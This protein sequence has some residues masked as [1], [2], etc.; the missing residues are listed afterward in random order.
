MEK[1][2]DVF[3]S[4]TPSICMVSKKELVLNMRF[5]D[6]KIKPDGNY[7]NRGQITTKNVVAMVDISKEKWVIKREFL[8]KYDETQDNV[9]AGLEDVRLMYHGGKLLFN[10]NRGM[11]H[12]NMVIEH[13]SIEGE[14]VL[15]HFLKYEKQ[16][17]IEKNWVMFSDDK[18]KIKM[19]YNWFPILVGDVTPE[20]NELVITNTI[21]TPPF[22]R[23]IRG[24][25]NG[26]NIGN[27][28]WFL[29]HMVSY[30][31]RRYYYHI[32]VVLDSTT[33]ALKKYTPFF[34]FTKEKVEYSLGFVHQKNDDFLIGYSVLDRTTDFMTV[35]K[36]TIDEMMIVI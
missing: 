10:A 22:F 26:V 33:Y 7:E 3:C 12:G 1:E 13:G 29:S 34:T 8:L 18:Q 14:A 32:F 25:T 23:S 11:G 6:Y 2:L 21:E 24:S 19:I 9:Y 36:K 35:P 5:V 4:S 27:E 15:S 31:D 17:V 16:H 28:I 30:E 20:T